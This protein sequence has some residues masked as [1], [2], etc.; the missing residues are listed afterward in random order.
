[1]E[2]QK[3]IFICVL[4]MNKSLMGLKQH[5]VEQMTEFSCSC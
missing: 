4:M 1:M 5:E 3:N 2:R